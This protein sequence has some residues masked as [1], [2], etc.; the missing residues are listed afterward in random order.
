MRDKIFLVS[1]LALAIVLWLLFPPKRMPSLA[2]ESQRFSIGDIVVHE[3]YSGDVVLEPGQLE[4]CDE[5]KFFIQLSRPE[6]QIGGGASPTANDSLPMIEGEAYQTVLSLESTHRTTAIVAIR[7]DYRTIEV[8]LD[9]RPGYLHEFALEPGRTYQIP[10][11]FVVP[12]AGQYDLKARAYFEPDG[13]FF[14]FLHRLFGNYWVAG[15]GHT[16][17]VGEA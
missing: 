2:P 3:S 6:A 9:G 1:L 11:R 14:D 12:Q 7:L 5:G 10:L 4:C 16:I 17:S 8:A 13:L 15:T